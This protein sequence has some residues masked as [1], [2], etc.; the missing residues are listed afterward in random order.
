MKENFLIKRRAK[1]LLKGKWGTAILMV[2]LYAVI[3][4]VSNLVNAGSSEP[5]LGAGLII[6]ILSILTIPL[7]VGFKWAFLYLVRGQDFK[8]E[9]IFEPYTKIFGKSILTSI[10]QAILIFLWSLPVIVLG[11]IGVVV[12]MPKYI[13]MA[14][15]GSGSGISGEMILN[16]ILYFIV[17]WILIMVPIIIK[18]ISYSQTLF[19]LKDKPELTSLETI[20][21]SK[22]MMAGYKWKYFT[23]Y[24]SFIGWAFLCLLTL[25]IGFLWLV[26]Y[27]QTSL[28]EFYNQLSGEYFKV[29]GLNTE[30]ND[31]IS[32]DST[33]IS[34]DEPNK[35]DL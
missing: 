21:T 15:D 9:T 18:S 13:D 1:E 33:I 14:L 30:R 35:S 26:P 24:L 29:N 3:S 28:A 16:G 5:D 34:E 20:T 2:I 27:V 31:I 22:K 6:M 4:S 23:L 8:I 12:S 10:L 32:N 25:G 19:I 7:G 11:V 17:F